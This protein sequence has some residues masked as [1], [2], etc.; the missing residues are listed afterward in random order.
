MT[1]ANPSHNRALAVTGIGG[2]TAELASRILTPRRQIPLD[3]YLVQFTFLN[4]NISQ[5][6]D[7]SHQSVQSP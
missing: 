2:A 1:A 3:S 4:N 7:S 6:H 5:A